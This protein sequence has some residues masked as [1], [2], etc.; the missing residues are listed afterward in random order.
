MEKPKVLLD[1]C[2]WAGAQEVLLTN[3]FDVKWVGN[4]D[5]D[6]GDE[7]IIVLAFKENRV[8]ITLDKDFGELVFFRG[9]PH[10]GIVRI[11]GF[12]ATQH[13]NISAQILDR[14]AAD[15]SQG[16]VITVE[17]DRVRIRNSEK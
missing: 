15:L 14:Y 7:A 12:S 1:S 3:G 6:P 11:A 13:G 2:V 8:L 5:E 16:A 4:F 9:K 10:A 17:K